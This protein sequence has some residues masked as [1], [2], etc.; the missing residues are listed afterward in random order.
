MKKNYKFFSS[1]SK[2]TFKFAAV[3]LTAT[4]ALALAG[5]KN[6]SDDDEEPEIYTAQP[7]GSCSCGAYAT[8]Y[9]LAKT[10]QIKY[11]EIGEKAE[12]IYATPGIQFDDNYKHVSLGVI[13]VNLTEYSDPR[14]LKDYLTEKG[15]ATTAKFKMISN[16]QTDAEMI[17]AGLATAPS[18]NITPELISSFE[19]GFDDVGD[20]IFL[21]IKME[22]NCTAVTH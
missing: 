18:I 22:K 15:C 1:C 19:D 13:S 16:P 20:I 5:C 4:L 11:S 8:A 2:L 6:P 9:Y 7:E 3:L 17:L 21:L 10:G 12:A 14:A